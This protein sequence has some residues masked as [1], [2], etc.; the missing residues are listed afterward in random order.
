M[1][2]F[3]SDGNILHLTA[4]GTG[5]KYQA[6]GWVGWWFQFHS[7]V[8]IE[9]RECLGCTVPC[10]HIRQSQTNV[11]NNSFVS[12]FKQWYDQSLSLLSWLVLLVALVSIELISSLTRVTSVK[13]QKRQ[14][15]IERPGPLD[16]TKKTNHESQSAWFLLKAVFSFH[17]CYFTPIALRPNKYFLPFKTC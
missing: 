1:D 4:G 6:L 3:T 2:L 13:S 8:Y 14:S 12:R 5:D 15:F 11:G 7:T 9:K 10:A 17:V 16:R